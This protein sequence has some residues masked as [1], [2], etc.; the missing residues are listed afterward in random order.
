MFQTLKATFTN[1]QTL[2][3]GALAAGSAVAIVTAWGFQIIGR[4]QP[5]PLCLEQRWPYYLGLP[6]ALVAFWVARRRVP[7]VVAR[8]LLLVLAGLLLWGFGVALYQTGAQWGWWQLASECAATGGGVTDA[9]SLMA[10]LSTTHVVSCT[11]VSFTLLG[12]SF[13][14][15]NVLFSLAMAAIAVAGAF[16][17]SEN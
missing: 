13:A 1:R 7:R 9:G 3:A 6:V 16:A 4:F 8:G 14:G 11:E 10:Q 2:A 12:L 5:C 15:W 17:R